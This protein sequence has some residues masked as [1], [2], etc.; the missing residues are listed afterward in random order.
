M[1]FFH[2]IFTRSHLVFRKHLP[3]GCIFNI[4]YGTSGKKQDSTSRN[5][6]EFTLCGR[7]AA[8]D[9]KFTALNARDDFKPKNVGYK[10]YKIDTCT[11]YLNFQIEYN[12]LI[13]A[14]L[15]ERNHKF[16]RIL[17]ST[18]VTCR[19]NFPLCGKHARLEKEFK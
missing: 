18:Y 15:L 3:T 11:R 2:G 12:T 6:T 13:S 17:M 14:Q 5:F 1:E 16:Q 9:S 4:V 10:M 7:F 8:S 19:E